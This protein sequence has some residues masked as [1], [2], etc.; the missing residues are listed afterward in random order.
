M[1][2]LIFLLSF[3]I[4]FQ[5]CFS[6]K[7]VDYNEIT[8]V[9]KQKIHLLKLGSYSFIEGR[10]VS[11]NENTMILENNGQLQTILR[12]EII[13]LGARKISFLKSVRLLTG[14]LFVAATAIAFASF[15][16]RESYDGE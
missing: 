2:K 11:K 13:S 1:N 4:L 12:K 7:K 5:S 9:K 15:F 10:L 3:S 8:S 16:Q 6:Y 14:V